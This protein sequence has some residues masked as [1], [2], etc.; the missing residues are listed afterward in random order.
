MS[1]LRIHL[2]LITV[3][4]LFSA[5]YIIS[6]L[7]V[8]SFSPLTFGYLRV[9][10]SAI[11]LNLLLRHRETTPLTRRDWLKLIAYSL[12]GVVI[13]QSFFLVGL[14]LTS[15]HIAAI[16]MTMIP[17]FTLA[18]AIVLRRERATPAKIAGILLAFSGALL[19]VMRE[20]FEGASK[21]LLGDWLLII[22]GFAYA[23]YLV[24]AKRD[25]A[26]LTPRR[27]IGLVFSIGCVGMLP[28]SA[29]SLLH[30]NWQA[31]PPR[32]W[33]ALVLVILG[34]TVAAYLLNAWALAHTNSSLVATYTYLQPILTTCLAAVWLN[35]TIGGS[36]VIAAIMIFAGVYL[37]GLEL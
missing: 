35:E 12:L 32:A 37:S 33:V 13:N 29:H 25:M 4:V 30:E 31:I 36:T 22:N 20:G 3:A 19:V 2:A 18:D 21:S 8:R 26:R 28:I 7:A 14:S 9:L 24:V 1:R 6:K 34:P 11:V 23:L 17:V 15:A 10:G 27:V 16:L 5:N